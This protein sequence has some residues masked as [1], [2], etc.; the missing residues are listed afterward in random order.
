MSPTTRPS[1]STHPNKAAF[2]PG[3]SGPALRALK[4][5]GVRS[6]ADLPQWTESDL[7]ALHGMGPKAVEILRE[8]LK[9]MGKSFKTLVLA[10]V[11]A[12]T[13]PAL[14]R[15]Q[16]DGTCVPVAERAGRALG[17]FITARLEIGRLD[18]SRPLYWHFDSYAT[19]ASAEKARARR[20][21]VV[22][23]I[24]RIWLSRSGREIAASSLDRT[25][26]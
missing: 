16:T 20:S 22:E 13:T 9:S 21:T 2:P 15:A 6:V 11:L 1:E 25:F 23:S 3:V 10:A 19:R 26:P 8:A 24:G 17:C 5:A 14:L 12:V 4:S 7:A 18:S